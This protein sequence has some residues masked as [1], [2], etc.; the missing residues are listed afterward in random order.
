MKRHNRAKC[1]NYA[2]FGLYS[3]TF[4]VLIQYIVF[5]M[6]YFYK[7]KY[8]WKPNKIVENERENSQQKT[9]LYLMHDIHIKL[10]KTR[11]KNISIVLKHV[12]FWFCC[13][14]AKQLC[15]SNS[16]ILCVIVISKIQ[17][18]VAALFIFFF[19]KRETFIHT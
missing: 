16:T 14:R 6:L 2:R 3:F 15:S 1:W 9:F 19:N 11:K 17:L 7:I 8:E 4:F 18:F 13:H 12:H 10:K 5:C